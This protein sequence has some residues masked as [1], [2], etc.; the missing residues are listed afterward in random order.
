[1]FPPRSHLRRAV[2]YVVFLAVFLPSAYAIPAPGIEIIPDSVSVNGSFVVKGVT[3]LADSVRMEYR[4]IGIVQGNL[5][6]EFLGSIPR[7]GDIWTCFFSNDPVI[8]TC[9]PSPYSLTT[10][11]TGSSVDCA[12]D[13]E[14]YGC[15][16]VEMID[17]YGKVPGHYSNATK[18]ITV[19]GI[20]MT[21]QI[22]IKENNVSLQVSTEGIFA[23]AYFA[24]YNKN[25]TV[26]RN[27][28]KMTRLPSG[29]YSGYFEIIPGEF[30]VAFKAQSSD[31]FGGTI[32]NL[33][34]PM[35]AAYQGICQG[36][37]QYGNSVIKIDPVDWNPIINR[38]KHAE[39][40]SF[41]ITNEGNFTLTNLS[42][43]VPKE[44]SDYVGI[45][46]AATTLPKNDYIYY[47]VTIDDVDTS[48]TFNNEA[49]LMSNST[50][51]AAIPIKMMV[52]VR[53]QCEGMGFTQ[54]PD[55]IVS[56]DSYTLDGT[57]LTG[58][59]NVKEIKLKNSGQSDLTGLKYVTSGTIDSAIKSVSMPSKV[60]PGKTEKITVTF[61]SSRAKSY[62]GTLIINTNIGAERILVGVNFMEDISGGL[63]TLETDVQNFEA[64]LTDPPEEVTGLISGIKSKMS[65]AKSDYDSGNYETAAAEYSDASSQ[66][67]A[68]N[69]LSALVIAP[70]PSGDGG[71][72]VAVVLIVIVVA[73]AAFGAW[74]YF[75]KIKKPGAVSEEGKIENEDE[76]DF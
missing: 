58:T 60:E 70:I 18:Q 67:A 66:Y 53:D 11:E 19:G 6:E 54:A 32:Y 69:S 9:G 51:V 8:S 35:S 22:E 17:S 76:L 55:D 38:S 25:L 23:D 49:Y 13:P 26:Y 15:F 59:S 10:K 44:I 1:M 33:T 57:F 52:S 21:P 64:G 62:F 29:F 45:E 36:V 31:D 3:G 61:E 46:L 5:A 41:K 2:L 50:K 68:L 74:Y 16:F 65:A 7:T 43:S 40:G 24:V 14:G 71:A 30:F 42:V 27:Y 4:I 12:S 20:K 39:K 37:T 63:A 47:T 28:Q 72:A 75:T 73:A 48:M 34:I 56:F